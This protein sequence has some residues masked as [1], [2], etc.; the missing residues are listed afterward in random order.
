M[1][2][3]WYMIT[4]HCQEKLKVL[5]KRRYPS[6]PLEIPGRELPQL[7]SLDAIAK[8]MAQPPEHPRHVK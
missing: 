7:E 8:I 5:Q 6:A 1:P 2:I 3:V 4:R